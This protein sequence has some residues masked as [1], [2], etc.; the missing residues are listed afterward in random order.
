MFPS[1]RERITAALQKLEDQ[2]EVA[3]GNGASEEEVV[4]AKEAISQAKGVLAVPL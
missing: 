4:K 1:L 2:L 3:E